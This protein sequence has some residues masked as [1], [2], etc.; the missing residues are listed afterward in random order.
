MHESFSFRLSSSIVVVSSEK[1]AH[2]TLYESGVPS[3][4][5]WALWPTCAWY[6]ARLPISH[7]A[8]LYWTNSLLIHLFCIDVLKPLSTFLRKYFIIKLPFSQSFRIWVSMAWQ[9]ERM[10][11][12]SQAHCRRRST[13]WCACCCIAH[14]T[15]YATVASQK[16]VNGESKQKGIS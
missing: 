7:S 13:G 15:D 3:P 11:T 1:N 4:C 8:H 5:H 16:H 10:A 9:L 6:Y 2:R 14:E 12:A